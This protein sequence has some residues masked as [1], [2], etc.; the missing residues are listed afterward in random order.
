MILAN[1]CSFLCINETFSHNMVIANR[2][3]CEY[4]A[5]KITVVANNKPYCHNVSNNNSNNVTHDSR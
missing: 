5:V 2:S 4:I 3:H 1:R